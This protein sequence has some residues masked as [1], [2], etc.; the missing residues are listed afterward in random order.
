MTWCGMLYNMCVECVKL[1]RICWDIRTE[2]SLAS[3]VWAGLVWAFGVW[4]WWFGRSGVWAGED[5]SSGRQGRAEQG[6]TIGVPCHHHCSITITQ[7]HHCRLLLRS[8]PI[9][10]KCVS[11]DVVLSV[12]VRMCGIWTLAL[13]WRGGT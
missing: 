8:P 5:G 1:Y 9:G 4:L 7:H 13:T 12:T 11:G 2:A 6:V 3:S 10:C